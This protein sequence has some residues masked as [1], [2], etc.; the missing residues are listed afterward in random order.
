MRPGV[1]GVALV[2]Q[3]LRVGEV[4]LAQCAVVVGQLVQRERPVGEPDRLVER[5]RR[6]MRA[7]DGVLGGGTGGEVDRLVAVFERLGERRGRARERAGLGVR[8][9]EPQRVAHEL[10]LVDRAVMLERGDAVLEQRERAGDV[11]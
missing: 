8:L 3:P 6:G 1:V 5:A 10:G 11:A 7:R 9:A 2:E 4:G